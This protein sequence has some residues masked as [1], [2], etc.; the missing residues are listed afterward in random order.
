MLEVFGISATQ[1]GA[2]QGIYG[3]IAMLAYFPGGLIADHIPARKLLALS[4]WSTSI[5][6]LYMATAP[7]FAGSVFIWSFFGISTILLFWAALIRATRDWGG[8]DQQGRAFGLLDGGRG[9]LAAALASIG[10]M[11]LGLAFPDGYDAASFEEKRSALGMV[12]IGYATVTALA[13]LLVWF[14]IP[15]QRPAGSTVR[16][17]ST[18]PMFDRVISV[19]GIRAVWLQALVVLCAYTAYKG[20]DNYQLFFVDAYGIDAVEAAA[21]VTIGSW[22][23]PIAA[24]AAGVLG[25]RFNASRMLLTCFVLL[26]VSDLFFAFTTPSVAVATSW[27]LIGNTLLGCIAIFG[28]RGVYFALFGEARVPIAL[29][30]T[31]VG[32]VSVIGYTPDVFLAFVAGILIDASPGAAGHQ[33]VFVMLSVFAAI[34]AIASLMLMRLLH[35]RAS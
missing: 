19:L 30:G 10:V 12:I 2:A 7:G 34:G 16:S 14:A 6:G 9:L 32:V 21:I 1:L 29:T 24:L 13:G 22:M 27:M 3:V 18:R 15:H 33:D 28:L 11:A 23:R 35:A 20:F 25:D 5:G 26:L 17:N 4:L 8:S 31:A